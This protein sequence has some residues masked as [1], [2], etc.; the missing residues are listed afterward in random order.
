MAVLSEGW[1]SGV[2]DHH[3]PLVEKDAE[4]QRQ[5][6]GSHSAITLRPMLAARPL[7]GSQG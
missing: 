2:S 4:A 5:R 3:V 7:R 1:L 6:S